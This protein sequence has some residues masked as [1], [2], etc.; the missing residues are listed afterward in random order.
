MKHN[1]VNTYHYFYQTLCVYH[2]EALC[3]VHNVQSG[4]LN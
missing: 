3:E 4:G 2:E 1:F